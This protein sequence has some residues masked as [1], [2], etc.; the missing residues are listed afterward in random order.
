M[1][2]SDKEAEMMKGSIKE[3]NSD[4][5]QLGISPRPKLY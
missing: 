1:E 5:V 4:G 3:S 2:I